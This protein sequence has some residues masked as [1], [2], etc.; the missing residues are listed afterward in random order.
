MVMHIEYGKA[1][2]SRWNLDRQAIELEAIAGEEIFA[3]FVFR[4][5]IEGRW[6][7]QSSPSALL[8]TAKAHFDEIIQEAG[9][10]IS[11]GAAQDGEI[12]IN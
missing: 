10:L 12:Q 9:E 8:D 3:V 1:D 2:S 5:F 11:M 7:E 6:G 4:E